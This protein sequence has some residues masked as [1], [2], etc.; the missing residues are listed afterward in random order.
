MSDEIKHKQVLDKIQSGLPAYKAYQEVYKCDEKSALSN[1][2]RI[3][4][5]END[6]M[7]QALK[8]VGLDSYTIASEIKNMVNSKNDKRA[9]VELALKINGAFAPT[10]TEV[11]AEVVNISNILNELE[12]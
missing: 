5:M 9:G 11:K 10:K 6:G 1:A 4:R 3:F 7:K 2:Y 8:D 12:K